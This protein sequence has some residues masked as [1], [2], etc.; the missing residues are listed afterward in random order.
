MVRVLRQVGQVVVGEDFVHGGQAE[1]D[2]FR[3]T[4]AGDQHVVQLQVAVRQ[5]VLEGVAEPFGHVD[6]QLRGLQ[7]IDLLA[8]LDEILQVPALDEFH[9]EEM[10]LPLGND[11]EDGHDVRMPQRAA[12]AA[13]ADELA[14]L[15]RV[16]AVAVPQRLDRHH[17]AGLSVYGA[18][19]AGKRA[20]CRPG[21]APCKG[22]RRSRTAR[23]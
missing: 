1:I 12:D 22:R 13:F 4:G 14:V 5:A 11:L 23:L 20:A 8:D 10:S 7:R 15:R 18:K 19:H 21:T 9:H 16:L 17:L 3:L 2:Q 6:H